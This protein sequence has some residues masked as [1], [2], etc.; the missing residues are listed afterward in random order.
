M[1]AFWRGTLTWSIFAALIAFYLGIFIDTCETC[2]DGVP[3]LLQ[4]IKHEQEHRVAWVYLFVLQSPIMLICYAIVS[5]VFGLVIHM[6]QPLW[7]TEWGDE[8]K[9]RRVC[10]IR[11]LG[12]G[13]S[14]L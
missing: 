6:V 11:A 8:Y 2:T 14:I 3:H 1:L 4:T 9:V 7:Q 12:Q 13:L 10:I 5:Y